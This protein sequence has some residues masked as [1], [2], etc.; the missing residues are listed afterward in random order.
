MYGWNIRVDKLKNQY[1]SFL[2]YLPVSL[3]NEFK[4]SAYTKYVPGKH[5]SWIRSGCCI[6]K[7]STHR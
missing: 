1:S 4:S 5:H 6:K 7:R 2:S 3:Q